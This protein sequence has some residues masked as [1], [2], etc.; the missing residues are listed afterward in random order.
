M[1]RLSNS[2]ASTLDLRRDFD[3]LR[4]SLKGQIDGQLGLI[5]RLQG[6]IDGQQGHIDRLQ[7]Q[8]DGQQG[9]IGKQQGQIERQQGQIER[10]NYEIIDLKQRVAAPK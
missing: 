1:R 10:Q 9:Q 3:S 8:N 2:F 5:N 7:G 6:Q 4:A